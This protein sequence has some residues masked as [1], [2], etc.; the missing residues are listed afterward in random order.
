MKSADG[1]AST[2]VRRVAVFLFGLTL[3]GCDRCEAGFG[4]GAAAGYPHLLSVVVEVPSESTLRFQVALSPLLYTNS[5][6][7]RFLLATGARSAALYVFGGSGLLNERSD[8]GGAAGT[9]SFLWMGGGLCLPTG[10]VRLFGEV[11]FIG[12]T[13]RDKGFTDS[14]G[15]SVGILLVR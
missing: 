1:R 4:W 10:S 5:L 13:D 15:A 14:A 9:T 3:W 12:G 7:A 11:G 8:T 2:S 6:T